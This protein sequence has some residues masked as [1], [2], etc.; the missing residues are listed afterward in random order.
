MVGFCGRGWCVG[1]GGMSP[2]LA[3]QSVSHRGGR[4]LSLLG[5]PYVSFYPLN[6]FDIPVGCLPTLGAH[7]VKGAVEAVIPGFELGRNQDT[8]TY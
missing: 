2:M 1:L 6:R 8:G 5:S 3:G 7:L 4:S